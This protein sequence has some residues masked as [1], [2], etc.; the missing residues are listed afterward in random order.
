MHPPVTLLSRSG[1]T[2]LGA[3]APTLQFNKTKKKN[4]G[5]GRST[6]NWR[7][8]H[9]GAPARSHLTSFIQPPIGVAPPSRCT[10]SHHTPRRLHHIGA[11]VSNPLPPLLVPPCPPVSVLSPPSWSFSSSLVS[12]RRA[13]PPLQG[14]KV[15]CAMADVDFDG[16][17]SGDLHAFRPGFTACGRKSGRQSKEQQLLH[18]RL[19]RC[20]GNTRYDLYYTIG[21]WQQT[22][23]P[24]TLDDNNIA[25]ILVPLSSCSLN[26]TGGGSATLRAPR[27]TGVLWRSHSQLH[28][29]TETDSKGLLPRYHLRVSQSDSPH[30]LSRLRPYGVRLSRCSLLLRLS[31]R[32]RPRLPLGYLVVVGPPSRTLYLTSWRSSWCAPTPGSLPFPSLLPPGRRCFVFHDF[33]RYWQ[34]LLLQIV[35]FG[36]VSPLSDVRFTSQSGIIA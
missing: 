16:L 5:G 33:L 14:S 30:V 4:E 2:I 24:T 7:L 1:S 31:W 29:V 8:H 35:M 26:G 34:R 25:F 13:G 22:H 6:P 19:Q 9:I 17:F 32:R 3:P 23:T 15:I 27:P 18:Q 12:L 10:C 20:C 11:P 28:P 36:Y 21:R